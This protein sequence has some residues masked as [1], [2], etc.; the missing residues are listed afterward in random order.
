[1]FVDAAEPLYQ[2][3]ARENDR[4][5][6]DSSTENKNDN[7]G[8][9]QTEQTAIK[10]ETEKD[11]LE[12]LKETFEERDSFRKLAGL[13]QFS[14][15]RQLLRLRNSYRLL[16]VLN[17]KDGYHWNE[18]MDMLFWQEFMANLSFDD[19]KK[20]MKSSWDENMSNQIECG[21]IREIIK[22]VRQRIKKLYDKEEPE[23]LAQFVRTVVLPHS[24][25]GIDDTNKSNNRAG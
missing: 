3:K 24:E 4:M 1:L 9:V 8:N 19:R 6:P 12:V 22:A 25:E 2:E 14:N 7:K 5:A 13:F 20:R 23:K 18:L 15:P 21:R 17:K 11:I 16:K 10:E